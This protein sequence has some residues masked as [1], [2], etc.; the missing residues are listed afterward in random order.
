LYRL[1][2]G[3]EGEGEDEPTFWDDQT[4]ESTSL[5]ENIA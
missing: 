2:E 4:L 1:G 3:D 5:T